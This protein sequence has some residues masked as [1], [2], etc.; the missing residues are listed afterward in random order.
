MKSFAELVS[1]SDRV[2][3]SILKNVDREVLATALQGANARLIDRMLGGRSAE[4]IG[5][6]LASITRQQVADLNRIESARRQIAEMIEQI[7]SV[8]I[9]VDS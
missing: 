7:E 6:V 8:G 2:I 4:T 1:A 5:E 3:E 9:P